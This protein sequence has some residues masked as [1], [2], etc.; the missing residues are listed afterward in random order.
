M[1]FQEY[2]DAPGVNISYL[3]GFAK[4]PARSVFDMANGLNDIY[5]KANP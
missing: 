4:S 2:R 3:K 5:R 1:T